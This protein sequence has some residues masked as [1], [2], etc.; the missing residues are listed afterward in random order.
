MSDY[1]RLFVPGGTYFFTLVTYRRRPTFREGRARRLL[2]EAVAECKTR[3]PFR[4]EAIVLLPDHLHALWTLPEG[5]A[6]YS[7]RWGW[8]K[9]EFGRRYRDAGGA[10]AAVSQSQTRNRRLGVWQRRYW[11]H[12]V[13]DERDFERLFDYIHFNPVKHRLAQSP[14]AW[15]YSTFARWVRAGVYPEDWGRASIPPARFRGIEKVVGE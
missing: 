11:E 12:T 4:I 10:L 15:P 13:R 5:D 7:R 3:W 9:K 1:R 14:A 8:I 2:R 6:E